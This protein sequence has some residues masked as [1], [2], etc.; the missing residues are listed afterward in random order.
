MTPKST[1]PDDLPTTPAE[2]RDRLGGRDLVLIVAAAEND[3][4]GCGGDLP[5]SLP[6]DMRHFMSRTRGNPVIMGRRTF[7]SLPRPLAERTNIVVTRS[8]PESLAAEPSELVIFARSFAEALRAAA[9]AP[10][11]SNEVFAAGGTSIYGAAAP[12]AQRIDLT[13]VHAQ[14]EGDTWFPVR[15]PSPGWALRDRREGRVDDRHRL[16]HSFE[17]WGRDD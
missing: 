13:R 15:L 9:G 5:W 12:I 11:V 3:V 10:S 8:A 1:A 4:I 6:D 2:A 16:R 17:V 14:P 7:Q